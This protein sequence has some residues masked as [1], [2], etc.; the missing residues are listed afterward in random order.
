[1]ATGWPLFR[2]PAVQ[3]EKRRSRLHRIEGFNFFQAKPSPVFELHYDKSIPASRSWG[4]QRSQCS[5][6]SREL[7]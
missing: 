6:D 1:M 5:C 3:Q 4:C 2:Q 7:I